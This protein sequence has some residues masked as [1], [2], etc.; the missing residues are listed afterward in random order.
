MISTRRRESDFV[1]ALGGGGAR[2]LAHIGV[3]KV[4]QSEKIRIT[5]IAGVSMGAF[6]GAMYAYYMD[7]TEIEEIFKKFL[8]SQFHKKFSKTFF[9]L[10]EDANSYQAPSRIIK[11][12][13]RGYVYLKAASKKGIFSQT[14]LRE[15][16]D[17]LL[18]DISFS[19]LRIPFVSVSSD[20]KSGQ[21]VIFKNGKVRHAVVASSL[22]PGIVEPLES[23]NSILT[24]GST[25][26]VVPVKAASEIF[27]GTVVAVDVSM[28]LKRSIN[29]RTAFDVA[30]RANE[31]T[32]NLLNRKNLH[33]AEI[34][35]SPKVGETNWS[36]FDKLSEL[37][38]AGEIAA[39]K[40]V[41][42]LK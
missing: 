6:I 5:G 17:F 13:G 32:T 19:D 37:I 21:S 34:V 20:L 25:T 30:I 29:L 12:L 22:I 38:R 27:H 23:G 33:A 31:I 10:S 24:D 18:P 2:G 1:L 36:N 15:T 7:A 16:I 8:Q 11:K 42:L 35:I 4:L 28:N 39:R 41:S 40:A 14:I 3:L 9:L 26:E